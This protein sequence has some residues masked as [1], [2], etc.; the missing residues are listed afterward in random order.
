M[1][2]RFSSTAGVTGEDERLTTCMTAVACSPAVKNDLL[3]CAEM[4][5][6]P[7]LMLVPKP[8]VSLTTTDK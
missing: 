2:S 3:H 8:G 4:E 6:S 5:T 7:R 1:S